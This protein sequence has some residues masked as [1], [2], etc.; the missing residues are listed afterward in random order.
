MEQYKIVHAISRALCDAVKY[1]E[2]EVNELL[3]EGWELQGGV[4]VSK[5]DNGSYS[6]ACQAMVKKEKQS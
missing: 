6:A 4:S 3:Q 2:K 5:A 1:L